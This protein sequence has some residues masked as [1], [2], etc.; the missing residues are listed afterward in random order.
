MVVA[1]P[2]IA[3]FV[4]VLDVTIVAIALPGIQADFGLSTTALGWVITLYALV[5]G[6]GL[7]AAGRFVGARSRR[8]SARS[9]ARRS[10]AGWRPAPACCSWA[11]RSRASAPRSSPR[12]RSRW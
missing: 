12:R 5:F 7:P 3:Q 8:G 10:S 6:G 9:A 1:L 11:G 4:I 2:C